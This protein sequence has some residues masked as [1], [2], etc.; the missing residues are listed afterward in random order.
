MIRPRRSEFSHSPLGRP[1]G[2]SRVYFSTVADISAFADTFLPDGSDAARRGGAVPTSP[3]EDNRRR[4]RAT[5]CAGSRRFVLP[6]VSSSRSPPFVTS[7]TQFRARQRHVSVLT[8][9]LL[10][11]NLNPSVSPLPP[12]SSRLCT[13]R[14]IRLR[15]NNG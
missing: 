3:V 13:P 9:I 4:D 11:R 8:R 6:N 12:S 2:R 15:A 14:V 1:C 10:N 5:A 7:L